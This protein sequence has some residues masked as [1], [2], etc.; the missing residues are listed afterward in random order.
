MTRNYIM[1]I[2]IIVLLVALAAPAAAKSKVPTANQLATTLQAR[3]ECRDYVAE[4]P[5]GI[6]APTSEGQCTVA[7]E[8]VTI[9]AFTERA[10][11]ADAF[12]VATIL[13]CAFV[14]SL[15]VQT[16]PY[17]LGPT[18]YVNTKSSAVARTV[19]KTLRGKAKLLDCGKN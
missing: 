1:G 16:V 14:R 7:G 11:F 2:S 5:S 4:T 13:G 12:A 10:Q 19:A 9:R 6:A 8:Q 3:G 18:W 15:G 17:T